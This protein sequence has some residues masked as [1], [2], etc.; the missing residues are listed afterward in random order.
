[1][2]E[3]RVVPPTT[4]LASLCLYI[5]LLSQ[6]SRLGPPALW[7]VRAAPPLSGLHPPYMVPRT[8]EESRPAP[9]PRRLPSRAWQQGPGFLMR[10]VSTPTGTS[11]GQAGVSPPRRRP[12]SS[13]PARDQ[14][15]KGG[16]NQ[17]RKPRFW[18][19]VAGAQI[20][21]LSL[22]SCVTLR[23]WLDLFEPQFSSS[24]KRG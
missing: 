19:Q 5:Q 12:Q 21:A 10:A 2:Q 4:C 15:K 3:G 13:H 14:K 18:G 11:S 1:M 9:H 20:R 6:P 22:I 24:G 17:G 23:K 8:A 16:G 7:E